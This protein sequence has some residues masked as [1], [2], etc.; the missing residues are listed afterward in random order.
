MLPLVR[1]G[2]GR[3]DAQSPK[4]PGDLPMCAIYEEALTRAPAMQHY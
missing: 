3:A 1:I 2:A 4:L